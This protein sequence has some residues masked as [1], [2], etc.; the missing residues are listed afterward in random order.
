VQNAF[1]SA[2]IGCTVPHL[3]LKDIRHL[4]L[5][6]LPSR[7]EQE[8]IGDILSAYDDMI[9]NNTRR[10]AILEEMARRIFEEHLKC[11]GGSSTPVHDLVELTKGGDWGSEEATDSETCRV[12]IIRGTDFRQ[13]EA[14]CFSSIPTRYVTATNAQRKHLRPFDLIVENSVNAKTRAAGTPLLI[15]PG[16]IRSLED[17]ILPASFCRFFRFRTQHQSVVMRHY[18]RWLARTKQIEQFQVVA[19][20]GIANFQ[21]QEFLK[22]GIVPFDLSTIERLGRILA[23]FS[24]T[25]LQQQIANLQCQRDLLLPKLISGEIE[26]ESALPLPRAA[27]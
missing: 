11:Y 25:I 12:A 14:G 18:L 23:P 17:S 1:H 26:V 10:I 4:L 21:S 8:R 20:N 27:E 6:P 15:T 7:R 5:P 24:D 3:N 19:A 16:L 2:S 9:E 22:R 13:I